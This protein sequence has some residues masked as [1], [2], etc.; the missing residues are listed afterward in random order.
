MQRFYKIL[1]AG[2][3]SGAAMA[4]ASGS[5]FAADLNEP[6]SFKDAPVVAA[7]SKLG[8][9][10][11]GGITN[12]Y[13]F[14]GLS[15]SHG[16]MA[17]QGGLDVTYGMFYTGLWTSNIDFNGSGPRYFKDAKVELDVY[18]GIKPVW[19]DIT[20]DFGVIAYTYPGASTT[21]VYAN[22]GK[23]V[24]YVE[25][26]AGAS[27]T[28]LK[29]LA[30]G[31]TVFYSPDTQMNNGATWV[32]EGTATKPL[33]KILNVDV[34]ASG[35]VGYFAFEES[36]ASD[37][38]TKLN[39]YTYGNIG[40]TGTLGKI[41]L[42]VRYWDSTLGTNEAPATATAFEGGSRVVGTLKVTLP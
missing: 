17:G 8:I 15:Q 30:L 26:K 41:S 24:D 27:K 10:V 42:D 18:G 19:R 31:A 6:A 4:A 9:S 32:V 5:A 33:G 34:S 25:L 20:F 16:K 37:G 3:L 36:I 2:L 7:A 1:S 39:D 40:L 38:V 23:D 35:T 21:A 29:D 11:N 14:R 22:T 28:V 13:V 12:D